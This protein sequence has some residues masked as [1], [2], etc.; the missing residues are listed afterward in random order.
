MEGNIPI[1]IP[2]G[3]GSWQGRNDELRLLLRSLE[4]NA[5]DLGEVYLVTD[6]C[7]EWV[8]RK[9]L[10]VVPIP[11]IYKDCKDANLFNKVHST[12]KMHGIGDFVFSADD[13]VFLKPIE[14]KN[15]PIIHNHRNNSMFY[16]NSLTKWQNRVRNTLEWAKKQGVQLEHNFECHCPQLFNGTKII[17]TPFKYYPDFSDGKTIY[18]TW[19]VVTNSW[20]ESKPQLDFKETYEM[21]CTARD[22]VLDKLFIGYNDIGF[23]CIREKLFEAFG[24][25]SKWE[26]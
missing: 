1:I 19:R 17:Q 25:K 14:L 24:K 22:V 16:A 23:G 13:N 4:R 8:N 6:C 3:N 10:T 18:T 2:L 20:M 15:L 12:I 21:P 9:A 5:L 11:D 7:P 26:K